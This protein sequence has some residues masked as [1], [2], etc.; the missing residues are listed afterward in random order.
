MTVNQGHMGVSKD[1]NTQTCAVHV[2][3]QLAPALLMGLGESKASLLSKPAVDLRR[4]Q[5]SEQNTL[6]TTAG[7]RL[8]LSRNQ[9]SLNRCGLQAMNSRVRSTFDQRLNRDCCWRERLRCLH[10]HA[11][12]RRHTQ[13]WAV[14]VSGISSVSWA[15]RVQNPPNRQPWSQTVHRISANGPGQGTG[16][17]EIC[18]CMP[19]VRPTTRWR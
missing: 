15:S 1:Q 18:T 13:R 6:G 11:K 5:A 10:A 19:Q 4:G 9:T 7:P 16:T 14:I 17:P 3:V 8:S 2:S 12:L